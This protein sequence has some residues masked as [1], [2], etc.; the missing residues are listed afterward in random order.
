MCVCLV[1]LVEWVSSLIV[2]QRAEF[3]SDKNALADT[4]SIVIIGVR[5]VSVDYI[6]FYQDLEFGEE[7][8]SNNPLS[9]ERSNKKL[10]MEAYETQY[11]VEILTLFW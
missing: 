5:R 11:V 1:S 3:D 7:F 2:T 9:G 4:I 6:Y 8:I 10:K